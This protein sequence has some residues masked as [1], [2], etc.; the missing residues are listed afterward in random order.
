MIFTVLVPPSDIIYEAF[1]ES[2][3]FQ[4]ICSA[5]LLYQEL[6]PESGIHTE[7]AGYSIRG[8]SSIDVENL[9]SMIN[10]TDHRRVQVSTVEDLT[11]TITNIQY[12]QILSRKS[13]RL[14]K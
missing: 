7:S 14:L 11:Y 8:F 2:N 4:S 5:T 6:S 9:H 12:L 3:N 1:I 13:P 10:R